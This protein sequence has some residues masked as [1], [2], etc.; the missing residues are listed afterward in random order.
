LTR[1][2]SKPYNTLHRVGQGIERLFRDKVQP[3]TH[4]VLEAIGLASVL[5]FAGLLRLGWP[6]VNSFSFDEARLSLMAL[7]MARQGEFARLGMQSSAGVPN[8]PAAVWLFALPYRLSTDPLVATLFVGLSGALAVAG[9]WWLARRAWG[10][11][12]ALSAA[13]LFAASPFAVLYSRSIWSQD[14]LPPLAVLWA[15]AGVVGVSRQRAWALALHVFLAGFSLQ[16]HYAG[17]GLLPATAWL[18]LRYRLWRHWQAILAGGAVA[19]LVA[20]PFVHTI[21]CCAP[22]VQADLRQLWWQPAQTGVVAFRQL[23]QMAAGADW[24]WLLLGN[25]WTWEQ[26]L[27]MAMEVASLATALLVGLGLAALAWQA[28]RDTRDDRR[29]WRSVLTALLPAWAISAPLVFLRHKTPVFPQYQLAALPALFLAAGAVAGLVRRRWWGLP[30]TAAALAVAVIQAGPVARGLDVVSHRL[31]PGGIGTPLAKPRAAAR[32]LMDGRPIV[33][34]AH[35]DVP[36][37]FGDAAGFSVLLWDYPHRLVDGQSV[38]LIPDEPAH[39]LATF[40]DLPAWVEAQASNLNGEMQEFPRREGEPP[41]VA[42]TVERTNLSGFQPIE[43]LTLA[44]GAQL[45]GWGARS[46]GGRLRVTTWW[47]LVGPLVPGRYHQ[48]NHLRSAQHLEPGTDPLAVHD[49]P[50]S[51]HA[52]QEGDTL[53]TWADFDPPAEAGPFWMDM[54]MYTWPEI[55]RSPVLDRPGDPLSPIRLGPFEYPDD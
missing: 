45:R 16:V 9:L 3:R 21:W 35:G 8:F 13:L 20:W 26:P 52:W 39:L 27:S 46:A 11:W 53:V 30:I 15:V 47:K 6:G 31:T 44:N 22:G 5:A 41:Y 49:V 32:S 10:P 2:K 29:D 17:I 51:S 38:L 28:W 18:I 25:R 55:Q 54:G 4:H 48:F 14:L 42:L 34:H 40:A 23:G 36:E 12:A 7:Q 33:V 37:F 24:E 1:G 43:P 19:A 50:L